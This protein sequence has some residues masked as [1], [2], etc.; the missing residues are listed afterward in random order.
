MKIL[1]SCVLIFNLL[2][3]H[4]E[5][6][7][8]IPLK[9][10]QTLL[11]EIESNSNKNVNTKARDEI[12][13]SL[14]QIARR[15]LFQNNSPS[16]KALHW[17]TID[18]YLTDRMTRKELLQRYVLSV[19][20]FSTK[21]DEWKM[22]SQNVSS[23]C[24]AGTGFQRFLSAKPVCQWYG[25]HCDKKN[26]ITMI[27]LV[28]NGLNGTLPKE[29]ILLSDSL[30]FLWIHENELNDTL[31]AWI[32]DLGRLESLSLF[33]TNMK[34]TIPSTFEN[35][36]ALRS[37]RLHENTLSGT[38]P[39]KVFLGMKRLQWLWL[40]TNSFQGK[41]PYD[42]IG[43]LSNLEGLALDGM[44]RNPNLIAN[45]LNSTKLQTILTD[46]GV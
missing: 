8:E 18:E 46:C 43:R 19:L 42:S 5:P 16:Y 9:I 28:N 4:S 38:L 17:L 14:H 33:R 24:V 44:E 34:G 3:V 41:I 32:G 7:G 27:D 36:K 12:T 35:L 40:H 1:R 39:D 29:L 25:I 23:E 26:Q 20:Y 37:L 45:L 13:L 22:C 21:G 2:T 15:K 11:R 30:V 6:D 10:L 31:P